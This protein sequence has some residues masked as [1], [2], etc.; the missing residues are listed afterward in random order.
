MVANEGRG[1]RAVVLG[2]SG[3]VGREVVRALAARDVPTVFTWHTSSQVAA[4]LSAET[5]QTALQVDLRDPGFTARLLEALGPGPETADILIHCA[6][7]GALTSVAESDVAVWDEA[8]AVNC[9]APFLAIRA[10][11][12]YMQA[13]GRGD[14]VLSSA[15]DRSQTLPL[16]VPFAATQG[17]LSSMAMSMARELAPTGLHINVVAGGVI[18]GGLSQGLD[19]KLVQDYQRFSAFRRVG[20]PAEVAKVV[21]WLA[22]ENR[23]MNGKVLPVNGGI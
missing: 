19:P 17:M 10:L 15:L 22:L 11:L 9:R 5:G 14:V 6:A 12:P 18:E 16:P 13:R 21:V 7:V 2:G 3:A 8:T 20:S 1:R 4:D 23:Y